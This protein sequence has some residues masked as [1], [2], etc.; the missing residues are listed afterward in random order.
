MA[1]SQKVKELFIY[2]VRE[3]IRNIFDHSDT[4]HYYYALQSYKNSAC[5]EVVIADSGVG[6][7]NTIPFDEAS[8]FVT[9]GIRLGTP[10]MTTR[11]FTT[12][13]MTEVGHIIV[14]TLTRVKNEENLDGISDKVTK[15]TGKY[16][17]Y[18]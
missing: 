9:S 15:L 1:L 18:K 2:V 8:P 14:E 4:T 13:D 12:E 3:M 5:V 7:K 16:P 10:A 11:G 17:L 6:L